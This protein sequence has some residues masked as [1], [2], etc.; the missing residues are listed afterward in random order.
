[1]NHDEILSNEWN[2]VTQWV[3]FK[4]EVGVSIL[5]PFGKSERQNKRKNFGSGEK[6]QFGTS[7][8][9]E[10]CMKVSQFHLFPSS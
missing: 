7:P 5:N 4:L 3:R 8:F 1:V 9:V 10:S 2:K 6:V